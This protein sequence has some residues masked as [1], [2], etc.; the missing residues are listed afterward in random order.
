M[1]RLPHL[2]S[3]GLPKPEAGPRTSPVPTKNLALVKNNSSPW[4]GEGQSHGALLWSRC[5]G[6]AEHRG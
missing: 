1:L 5:S 6:L 4:L 2:G 3:Q